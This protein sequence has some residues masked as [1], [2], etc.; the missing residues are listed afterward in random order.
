[1]LHALIQ[2]RSG[3]PPLALHRP[4]GDAQDV[5]GLLD[6]ETAEESELDDASLLRVE[7]LQ[8]G[9]SPVKR[10]GVDVDRLGGRE[11]F[12]ERD[13]S[14]GASALGPHSAPR[15][16]DENPSHQ[17]RGDGE[18][19]RPVLPL[20]AA[21]IDELQIRLVHQRRRLERMVGSLAR[22]VPFGQRLQ[23]PVD[24]RHHL[25]EGFRAAVAALLEKLREVRRSGQGGHC[26]L[27]PD[28]F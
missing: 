15:V 21:L 23:L 2:P 5:G 16:V 12:D 13:P 6:G 18:E 4:G 1:V 11:T 20:H 14:L 25:V 26:G 17:L 3:N 27:L 28:R 19:V 8:V 7:S 10:D 9:E 22:K 24:H